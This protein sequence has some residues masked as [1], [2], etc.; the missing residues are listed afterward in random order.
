M[1]FKRFYIYILISCKQLSII[2]KGKGYKN[3]FI[4]KIFKKMFVYKNNKRK[5]FLV[6]G[7]YVMVFGKENF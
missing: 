7:I 5:Y 3:C 4:D 1:Y 6:F 2:K